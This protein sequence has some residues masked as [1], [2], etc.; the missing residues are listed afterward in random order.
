[1]KK[2]TFVKITEGK[3]GELVVRTGGNGLIILAM[4][5]TALAKVPLDLVKLGISL[6]AMADGHRETVLS[7]MKE[8][9]EDEGDGGREMSAMGMALGIDPTRGVLRKA[10]RDEELL[11][12]GTKVVELAFD[13]RRGTKEGVTMEEAVQ[14]V[15]EIMLGLVKGMPAVEEE[16]APQKE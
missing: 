10:V 5:Q 12:I 14:V 3:N 4:L 13:L 8:M 2:K 9:V 1:M 16:P 15:G 7:V 6:E 11:P